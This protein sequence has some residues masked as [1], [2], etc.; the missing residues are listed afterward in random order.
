VNFD[1]CIAPGLQGGEG[2]QED[3]ENLICYPVSSQ[4]ANLQHSAIT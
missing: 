3:Q 1:E 4:I 2:G